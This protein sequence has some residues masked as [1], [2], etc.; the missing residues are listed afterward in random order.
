MIPIV[1]D[2]VVRGSRNC[3]MFVVVWS[4][5]PQLLLCLQVV[6][7][8]ISAVPSGFRNLSCGCGCHNYV[9]GCK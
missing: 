2:A 3:T 4:I 5:S 6:L 9:C 1:V 8:N 7:S